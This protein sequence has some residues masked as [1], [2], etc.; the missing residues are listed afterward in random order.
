MLLNWGIKLA[1][2]RPRPTVSDYAHA[3][4]SWSF[5]SGHTVAATLF[6]GLVA[7]YLVSVVRSW[8]Q[9]VTVVWLALGCI[10]LVALSR[11]YLGVH[12]L[13]DVLAAMGVGAFWLALSTTTVHTLSAARQARDAAAAMPPARSIQN[14]HEGDT[15][16]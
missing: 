13:S 11:V 2:R 3:L 12:F 5:P 10:V 15:R 16:A 1:F 8:T 9:R 4:Q 14:Q 7:V 6:W